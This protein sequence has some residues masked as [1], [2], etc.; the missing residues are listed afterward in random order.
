MTL[1]ITCILFAFM[2]GFK[3]NDTRI[4]ATPGSLRLALLFLAA[5]LLLA[6]VVVL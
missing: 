5:A 4:D 1:L 3:F 2:S 6:V